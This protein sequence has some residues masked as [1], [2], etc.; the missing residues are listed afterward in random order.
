MSRLSGSSE[1]QGWERFR[2]AIRDLYVVKGHNLE[3]PA[4]VIKHIENTYEFKAT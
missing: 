4:G 2:N 1:P 3:G